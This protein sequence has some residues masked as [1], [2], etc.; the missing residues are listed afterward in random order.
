M[1]S[2]WTLLIELT[3]FILKVVGVKAEIKKN[4]LDWVAKK[5]ADIT[6][7]IKMKEE[8]KKIHESLKKQIDASKKEE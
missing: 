3:L 5:S 4:F 1:S 8:W 2:I 6:S 7:S